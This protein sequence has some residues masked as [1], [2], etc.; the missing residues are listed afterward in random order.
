MKEKD[1]APDEDSP[2]RVASGRTFIYRSGGW[3]DSEAASAPKQLKVKYL[4]DAYFA[5]LKARPE[6]KA[7]LALSD[8][9]VIV[10]A[11]GKSIVIDPGAGETTADAVTA[12]L[13]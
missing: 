13:W 12:F 9:L 11:K 3:V 7:A 6:L 1:K 2:A 8:R 4:S 10:V 5:L